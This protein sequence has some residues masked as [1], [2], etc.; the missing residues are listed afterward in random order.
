MNVDRLWITCPAG[1]SLLCRFVQDPTS[2]GR[3]VAIRIRFLPK[4]TIVV[5]QYLPEKYVGS[6]EKEAGVTTSTTCKTWTLHVAF[7]VT[8]TVFMSYI[9]SV[10]NR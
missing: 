10:D 9:Q 7:T 4:G 2:T 6:V 8:C 1:Y 5:E 3:L